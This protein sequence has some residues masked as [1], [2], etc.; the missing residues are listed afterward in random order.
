[1]LNVPEV[2][3]WA[4]ESLADARSQ[5][6]RFG[7]DPLAEAIGPLV[8]LARRLASAAADEHSDGHPMCPLC[9]LVKEAR[10]VGLLPKEERDGA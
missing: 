4:R 8:D 2:E 5:G 1:M 3:D 7:T 10:A 9:D 6:R